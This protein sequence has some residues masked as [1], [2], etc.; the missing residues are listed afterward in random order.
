MGKQPTRL[1]IEMPASG[2]RDGI[3]ADVGQNNLGVGSS[4]ISGEMK[5]ALRR[6]KDKCVMVGGGGK[7]RKKGGGAGCKIEG[8]EEGEK[9]RGQRRG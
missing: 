4:G 7:E 2:Q 3:T 8:M 9:E 6:A 5:G 1:D